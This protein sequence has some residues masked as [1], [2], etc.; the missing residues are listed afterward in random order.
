VTPE[1]IAR[2]MRVFS[3]V[4]STSAGGELT[5]CEILLFGNAEGLSGLL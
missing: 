3:S 5:Q 2:D 1:I 4:A